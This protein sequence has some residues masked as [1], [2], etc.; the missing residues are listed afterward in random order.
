MWDND[1]REDARL[2]GS[3]G[4][5]YRHMPTAMDP[6][7]GFF[8]DAEARLYGTTYY[9]F[10]GS[11]P[12]RDLWELWTRVVSRVGPRTRVVAHA[13]VGTGEPVLS[14]DPRLVRRSGADVRVIH[15]GT[16][17]A[18]YAKFNDWGPYDYHRDFNLTY[19]VQVMGD[20]SYSLGTPQWFENIP[21]TRIGVR[22][23]WRSLDE[24]SPRYTERYQDPVTGEW[25]RF[26]GAELGSEWEVRTYLRLAL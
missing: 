5:V 19:P 8:S 12:A 15:G 4:F 16:S 6:A 17:L 10:E 2:A 25:R 1:V 20:L 18:A 11:T 21:Q 22:A 9:A 24:H 26:E 13:Y 3:L 23:A 7:I 14:D